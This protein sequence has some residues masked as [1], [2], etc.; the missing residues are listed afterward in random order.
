MRHGIEKSSVVFHLRRRVASSLIWLLALGAP[1]TAAAERPNVL[2]AIS[3]DQSYPYAS[4]YGSK[5]AVTPAFDRVARQGVL[6]TAAFSPSPGC[7]PSRASFLTGPVSLA[8]RTRRDA[9]Q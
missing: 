7:S 6:F 4:A 1:E 3:D 2:I 5:A 9:W 8:T